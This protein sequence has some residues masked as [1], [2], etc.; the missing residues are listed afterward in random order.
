LHHHNYDAPY[1]SKVIFLPR[2]LGSLSS[3]SPTP[4][5]LVLIWKWQVQHGSFSQERI[6]HLYRLD[7]GW[8]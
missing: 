7:G 1:F 5:Q 8:W 2:F 6:D 3:S 4:K